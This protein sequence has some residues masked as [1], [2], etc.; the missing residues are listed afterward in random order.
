MKRLHNFNAGPAVLP[1]PVLERIRE[2]MLCLP[3]AGMSVLEISHRSKTFESILTEAEHRLRRLLGVPDTHH[4][5]FLQGGASLQFS[6]LPLNFLPKS[7]VADYILTGSWSEKAADEARKVGTVKIAA[8]TRE[9]NYGRIPQ[10]HELQLDPQAAYVHFTSNNT[11]F[12][13]QWQ[14]EPETGNVPLVCDASSDFLSRPLDVSRYALIYAGAQKNAGPAG[15]TIVIIRDDWL[16]RIAD[17]LPTMLDYRTHVTHRS[18]Y[19]TPPVFAIYVVGL[20][21][22]YLE[23]QGGLA[24]VAAANAEKAGKLY[25]AIDSGGFYRGTAERN[26]RSLMNVCFRLPSP[27]LEAVFLKEASANGFEGLPGHRSVGGVRASLYNALP[28]ASVAA[29]VDFMRDF[30]RCH[31]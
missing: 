15:V 11:I 5:L 7:G 28:M 9:E 26:S 1:V 8:T 21:L 30:A 13:T 20:V 17:G 16:S 23:A 29:L 14:T 24:A 19:N 6:M 22:E 4:I 27:G 3:E 31:G 12:G 2:E 10:P 25:A 18:L